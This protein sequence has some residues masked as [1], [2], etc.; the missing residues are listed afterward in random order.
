M[1]TVSELVVFPKRWESNAGSGMVKRN[2]N[3]YA[4]EAVH[5]RVIMNEM[6]EVIM[7]KFK[8]GGNGRTP[9]KTAPDSTAI[10]T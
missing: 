1:D 3:C 7:Y 4:I 2:G 5:G 9:R 10:S 6:D 8:A